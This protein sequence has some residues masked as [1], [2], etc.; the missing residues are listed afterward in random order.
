M[1]DI[2][3]G[4][5]APDVLLSHL[6][7]YGLAAIL[8]SGGVAGLRAGWHAAGDQRPHVSAP[9]LTGERAAEVISRHARRATASGSWLHRSITLG[10][11]PRALMSPRLST[12]ADEAT[13]RQAQRH[14][15]Q[16]LD[17][18]TSQGRWL[19]LRFLAALGEP[20]YWIQDRQG[21]IQQDSAASK[22][23]MQ[24]RNQGS[25]FVGNRLRK[26]A[27]AVACRTGEQILAGLAG[28]SVRDEAEHD[29][30]NSRTATGLAEPGP[31]DNTVAWCALWGISQLP[32]AMR[33]RGTAVTTGHLGRR[34]D[35]FFYAPVWQEG[36]RPARLRA[37][38]ASAQVQVA[39]S[40]GLDRRGIRIPSADEGGAAQ[41]AMHSGSEIAAAC[42]WLAERGVAGVV[43]FPIQRFGSGNAPER[44]AMRG[45]PIP[46]QA[47][48]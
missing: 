35:E 8:E 37:V 24:P 3:L 40:T 45:E 14:R 9:G 11:T 46:V 16:V 21:A 33:V 15:H 22:L 38:L 12:I 2:T 29:A 48:T 42:R 19:D 47:G 13:W 10:G 41:A 7:L 20:C 34:R 30:V 25:E 18:L 26:V 43:R 31:T 5:C 44:R 36:W 23:E 32:L 28:T 6:A 1:S 4:G 27:D 17:Q 39:A